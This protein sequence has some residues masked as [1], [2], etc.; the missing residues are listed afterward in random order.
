VTRMIAERLK[1]PILVVPTQADD[2]CADFGLKREHRVD[3]ASGIGTSVDV[4]AEENDGVV[5]GELGSELA[6]EVAERSQ[7]AVDVADCNRRHVTAPA[8]DPIA[9][10]WCA[11]MLA[12]YRCPVVAGRA[13]LAAVDV[14]VFGLSQFSLD[15]S[16]PAS[17]C[18][19]Q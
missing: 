2:S 5:I 19:C 10:D 14:T 12:R 16:P 11:G 4:V 9:R 8:F 3:T 1:Q 18:S 17:L 15:S 7:V 13:A 6:K